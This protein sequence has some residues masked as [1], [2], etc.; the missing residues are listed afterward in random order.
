[1]RGCRYE[2]DGGRA[3]RPAECHVFEP[4]EEGLP[5]RGHV[6]I[7]VGGGCQGGIHQRGGRGVRVVVYVVPNAQAPLEGDRRVGVA[8]QQ[9]HLHFVGV[10]HVVCP[11]PYQRM[12]KARAHRKRGTHRASLQQRLPVGDEL[13]SRRQRA[14]GEVHV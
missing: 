2:Y 14:N 11:Y 3:D 8:E 5:L 4:R 10:R 13:L 9:R 12:K 7:G 6:V 1:M